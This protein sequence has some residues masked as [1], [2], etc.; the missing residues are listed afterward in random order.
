MPFITVPNRIEVSDFS[1]GFAP[2]G[3]NP[4]V[5]VGTE[6]LGVSAYQRR[7]SKLLDVVNFLPDSNTS[8][9]EVRA[10]FKRLLEELVGDDT[11]RVLNLHHFITPS[12]KY[13]IAVVTDGANAANNVRLYAIALSTLT[14]TRMDTAGTN[15]SHPTADHWG[16]G[17]DNIW[18]GGSRGNT[19]YSWDPSG[20]TWTPD[21]SI[22]STWK[23]WVNAV[24]DSVT[25][26]TEWPKDYAFTGKE[27]VIYSGNHYQPAH[28]MR[29][30]RSGID[31]D[32]WESGQHYSVGD[33]V[34]LKTTWASTNSYYKQFKCIQSHLS[35]STNKPQVGT[36]APGTY[37]QKVTLDHVLDDDGNTSDSWFFVAVAAQTSIAAWHADRLVMRYDDQ[38]DKSRLLYSAPIKPQK[39]EDIADTT[40]DPT[41]FAPGNDI[42]GQ[43]GGWFSVNDGKHDGSIE[44]LWSYG[45]YLLIFKRRAVWALSGSDDST[46][47]LRRIARNIGAVG[48][49]AVTEL[50]GLVYFMSDEGLYVTDGTQVQPVGANN[51]VMEFFRSRL[52]TSLAN[53]SNYNDPEL[54]HFDGFIWISCPSQSASSGNKLFTFVYDPRTDSFWKLDL[55][56]STMVTYR[57]EGVSKLAFGSN[58][59]YSTRDLVYQYDHASAGGQ[60]DTGVDTYAAT[61]ITWSIRLP[62]WS[63]GSAHAERRVRRVW[64]ALKM[65]AQTVTIK[66]YTDWSNTPADTFT[67]T[68][69]GSPQYIEGGWVPD[70][71][72][73]NVKLSGTKATGALYAVAVDTEPRRNSRYHTGG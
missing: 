19:M 59:D 43:G 55:P 29:Q 67:A 68:T 47:S 16:F 35:D 14:A 13:I 42:N 3:Q 39:G 8:A 32:N 10:G 64:A 22:S 63:F 31:F 56:A 66:E 70:A 34:L 30:D 48:S 65:A 5:D 28:S 62:W 36:G 58:P 61:D 69:T 72:A 40:W 2:D 24:D 1:G 60:D 27:R 37:W 46:W 15:W 49:R 21:A 33:R 41:N 45:P 71:H 17:I 6:V 51:N 50:D 44:A 52:D 18:Y 73:I 26:A 9:L 25:L 38:G 23:T 11:H 12:E 54:A 53:T 4:M 20:P 7:P 57:D